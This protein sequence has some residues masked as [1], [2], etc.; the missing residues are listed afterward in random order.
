M[1]LPYLT[2]YIYVS[3]NAI[4]GE[5]C[6]KIIDENRQLDETWGKHTWSSPDNE[7]G[8]LKF[9]SR[10]ENELSV[11]HVDD[12]TSKILFGCIE[13]A[14]VSYTQ[15]LFQHESIPYSQLSHPR[16]NRY[17]VGTNMA[18]HND[19]ISSLFEKGVGSPNLSIVGV[20]NDN[21]KGGEFI[22]FDN[23]EIHLKAGDILIFPS[24]FLYPHKVDTVTEGERWS[25]V[26]WAF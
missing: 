19:I 3:R 6:L 16:I 14:L 22:M 9:H 24:T 5:I 2:D 20:L 7:T 21:Y 18:K 15:R 10:D 12:A 4:A 25:F 17:G 13:N 23:T 8:N 1:N 11:K 26:S